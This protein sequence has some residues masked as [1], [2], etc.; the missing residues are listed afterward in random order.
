MDVVEI[1]FV[2]DVVNLFCG[3]ISKRCGGPIFFPGGVYLYLGMWWIFCVDVLDLFP[4]DL[5]VLFPVRGCGGATS[6]G[7]GALFLAAEVDLVDVVDL[8]P[9]VPHLVQ[10]TVDEWLVVGRGSLVRGQNW[11]QAG[12]WATVRALV[13]VVVV[14]VVVVMVVVGYWWWFSGGGGDNLCKDSS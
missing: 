6:S 1:L 14:V 10:P 12:G 3:Y 13:V 7:C 9:V 5:V 4:A 2:V 11:G 8:F